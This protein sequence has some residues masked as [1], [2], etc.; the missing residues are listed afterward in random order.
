VSAMEMSGNLSCSGL[1]MSCAIDSPALAPSESSGPNL[2][3]R[4]RDVGGNAKRDQV[5]WDK[6]KPFHSTVWLCR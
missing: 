6:K 4:A 5:S 3:T 1:S 2:N